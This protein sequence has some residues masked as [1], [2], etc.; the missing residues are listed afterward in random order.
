MISTDFE[1]SSKQLVIMI[2]VVCSSFQ[3][4]GIQSKK[5]LSSYDLRKMAVTAN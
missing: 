4:F 3:F 5:C 2:P 1:I